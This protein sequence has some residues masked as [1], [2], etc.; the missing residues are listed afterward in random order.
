MDSVMK[1][2]AA[3]PSGMLITR[4][5]GYNLMVAL[6]FG[7]RRGAL[8]RALAAASGASVRDHVLDVGCGPGR[9]ALA[10]ADAVGP[11]GH[12]VGVD[13]SAPMIDYANR[14]A[15][16]KANCRFELIPAQSLNLPDA[17]FDV[18]TSTFAM[19]HIP[20]GDRVE[21]L[22]HMFRVL[23]P[24]GRLLLADMHPSGRM[25]G[26]VLRA[27]TRI[28]SHHSTD[29]FEDV[30]VRRYTAALRKIGFTDLQFTTAKPWTGYLTAV[31]PG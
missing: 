11:Q 31:K 28:G 20:A 30:D 26:A 7:G 1:P 3:E 18:V 16:R 19:H 9:F 6:F 2:H 22:A 10:L 24:G 14:H 12:V 21:A 17:V 13:P 8:N 25:I 29:P 23:R 27:L 4:V 15:G 5:R